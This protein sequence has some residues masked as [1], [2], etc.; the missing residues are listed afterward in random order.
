MTGLEPF[1]IPLAAQ[2]ISGIAVPVFQTLC[3]NPELITL[4]AE[5]AKALENY[6]YANLLILQCK[7]AAVRVTPKTWEGIEERMLLPPNN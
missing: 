3:I 6:F 7:Q 1:A 2:A 5:E 4:S